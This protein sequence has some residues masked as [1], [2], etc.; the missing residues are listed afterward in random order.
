MGAEGR[1]A[2]ILL[3]NQRAQYTATTTLFVSAVVSP[4]YVIVTGVLADMASRLMNTSPSS[5][6]FRGLCSVNCDVYKTKSI[7]NHVLLNLHRVYTYVLWY[8]TAVAAS[9][10]IL[11]LNNT[12]ISLNLHSFYMHPE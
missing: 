6:S 2:T 4:R 11:A 3:L 7:T 9:P 12:A 5:V 8:M 10:L 1:L